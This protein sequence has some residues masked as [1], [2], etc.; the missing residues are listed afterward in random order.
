MANN[1]DSEGSKTKMAGPLFD[2]QMDDLSVSVIFNEYPKDCLPNTFK[3]PSSPKA[4]R[5]EF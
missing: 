1:F 3:T 5:L 2:V 4:K